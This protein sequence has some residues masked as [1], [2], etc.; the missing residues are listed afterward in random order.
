MA[1][2]SH[3]LAGVVL[4]HNSFGSHLNCQNETI[5][6]ELEMK[7]FAKAGEV[8]AE[9]WSQTVIDVYATVVECIHPET[10]EVPVIEQDPEGYGK[11]VREMIYHAANHEEVLFFMSSLKDFYFPLLPPLPISQGKHGLEYGENK[12]R[13]TFLSVFA[14]LAMNKLV[15]EFAIDPRCHIQAVKILCMLLTS[16]IYKK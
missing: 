9:I 3:D 4:P 6:A 12:C 11:H 8:L 16:S 13:N 5:D 1:P 7:N 2:L 15:R 10:D 14:N